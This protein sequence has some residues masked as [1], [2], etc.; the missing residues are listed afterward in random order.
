[1][2][3]RARTTWMR[4]VFLLAALGVTAFIVAVAL[5]PTPV[6]VE[7]SQVKSGPLTVTVDAEGKTRARDRFVVA[8][9]VTGRL[10]RITLHRGD[11][12]AEGAV[13]A[14]IEPLPMA[15]LDPRQLAE[16]KARV[17]AAEQ[18]KHEAEAG[19]ERVR[20]E[21][22]QA[23]RELARAEK[24]VETGDVSRQEFERARSAEQTCRQQLEAA[25]YR[26]SAA[27][28]EVEVAKAALLAVERAGQSGGTATVLVRAPVGGRVLRV[29]EESERVV[30]A[31]APLIE[32]S[33]PTLE[34]VVDV[35]SSDAVKVKPGA[36]VS[37]EG[38]GGE[39]SLPAR[40]RLIEPSGFTKVS[41]LGVEEQRV[42][43]IAD[44]VEPHVP[45]GD[46]Y[47]VEVK[48]V[49]WEKLDALKAPTSALFRRGEDWA[50]FVVENE[51]ARL[52]EVQAGRRTPFEAEILGGLKEGEEVIEHPP[53]ELKDGA[54]VA[55]I[56]R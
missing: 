34:I 4:I 36:A 44:F 18:L 54:R 28:S 2:T 30:M 35:L 17:A 45:L 24:L 8:A 52:R 22:E 15:P 9:P 20:A 49:V 32:L 48:I 27:A 10:A 7:V 29:A 25:R 47:R 23:R 42:N 50:A 37:V 31:G 26:A 12:A 19:V 6:R 11:A 51:I 40:V 3:R 39:Q 1:M 43:V 38:W 33:N 55:A 46:G 53:N 16:A 14:R 41:A 13:V 56:R 5:R 21:C